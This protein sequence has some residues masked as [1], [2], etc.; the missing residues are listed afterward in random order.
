MYRKLFSVSGVFIW[1]EG[2][3][4][5]SVNG[6]RTGMV[7]RFALIHVRSIKELTLALHPDPLGFAKTFVFACLPAREPPQK[8]RGLGGVF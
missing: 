3:M 4:R 7:Q 1:L 5:V 8:L 6:K 2:K